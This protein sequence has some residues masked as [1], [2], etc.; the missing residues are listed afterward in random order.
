ML[1]IA[2]DVQ[3]L[4]KG[5]SMKRYIMVVCL[6]TLFGSAYAEDQPSQLRQ[7]DAETEKLHKQHVKAMLSS[8]AAEKSVPQV[9]VIYGD[10]DDDDDDCKPKIK[11]IDKDDIE[12]GFVITKPG[13]YCLKENLKFKVTSTRKKSNNN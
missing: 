8:L 5:E 7:T 10:T 12:K 4:T 3:R 2:Y 13:V 11:F 1:R 6:L 9:T